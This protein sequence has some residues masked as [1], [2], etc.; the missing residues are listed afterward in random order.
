MEDK[1]KE[2]PIDYNKVYKYISSEIKYKHSYNIASSKLK[3]RKLYDICEV[4][5]NI[6]P[7][8]TYL[9]DREDKGIFS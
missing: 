5:N 9:D 2:N 8:M 7:I 3:N 1:E 4:L 6:D